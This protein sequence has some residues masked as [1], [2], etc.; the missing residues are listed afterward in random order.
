MDAAMPTVLVVVG[1]VTPADVTRLCAELAGRLEG[2][3]VTE[4]I[5]DVAGLTDPDLTAVDALA[6]LR[7]T[8]RRAGC[9]MRLHGARHDLL[10]LLRLVGL[11]DVA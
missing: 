6:R 1:R 3:F 5:C 7:L 10:A 9:R 8:A 11:T 2:T 4:V